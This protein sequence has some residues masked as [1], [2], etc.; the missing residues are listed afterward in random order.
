MF[1]TLSRF[2][3]ISYIEGLSYLIVV[4]VAMP[5]KY[6]DGNILFMKYVG[7]THGVLFILFTI[8]LIQYTKKFKIDKKLS[9]DFFI[10]SLS[11]FG[12]FLI[13]ESIK[14]QKWNKNIK[15]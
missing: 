9:I 13:E 1:N 15:R 8:F 14:E 10:Y 11:P 4:F 2:R 6:L 12:F 7:M 5:M 3:I